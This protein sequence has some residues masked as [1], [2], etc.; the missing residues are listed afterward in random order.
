MA[1]LF[2][3]PFYFMINIFAS[4]QSKPVVRSQTVIHIMDLLRQAG[5]DIQS[6]V[7]DAAKVSHMDLLM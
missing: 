3:C 4:A 1:I 2:S 7:F 5:P 6:S